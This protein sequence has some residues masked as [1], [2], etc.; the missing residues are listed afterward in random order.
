M[1]AFLN[2]RSLESMAKLIME[3]RGDHKG[4]ALR[5]GPP[6]PLVHTYSLGAFISC[7]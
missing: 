3:P 7:S 6:A 2:S 5:P 4:I 1:S